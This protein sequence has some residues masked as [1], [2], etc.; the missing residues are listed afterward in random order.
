M[1]RAVKKRSYTSPIRAEQAAQTRRRILDAAG[2]L[3]EAQ[4][5]AR[6]TMSAI[7]EASGVATD[8]VYAVLGAKARV[9]TALIDHR[10]APAGETSVLDRPEAQADPRQLL[11]RFAPDVTAVVE[12]VRPIYEVLRM[13]AA[14][15][16]NLA[17]IVVA[18]DR[19]RLGHM[20]E[21]AGWLAARGPL[22]V[23]VEEAAQILWTLTSPDVARMLRDGC[24]WDGPRHAA[25]LEDTLAHALLA[26]QELP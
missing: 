11:H 22:R 9:L 1:A 14:V 18:M 6:T 26:Q 15:D 19:S 3:F 2:E 12:R 20:R 8:T 16:A 25:W 5:Y 23:E 10:L 21:V 4:G 7:A 13:A 17:A 24:G